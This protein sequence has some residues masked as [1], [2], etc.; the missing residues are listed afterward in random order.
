[1]PLFFTADPPIKI[2]DETSNKEGAFSTNTLSIPNK[3]GIY[4]FQGHFRQDKHE[5][6]NSNIVS[7]KVDENQSPDELLSPDQRK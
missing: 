6:A 5:T 1:M 7:I 3:P 4:N 2:A